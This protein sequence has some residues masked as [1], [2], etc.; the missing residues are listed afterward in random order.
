MIRYFETPRSDYP[1]DEYKER[2]QVGLLNASRRKRIAQGSGTSVTDVNRLV[3]QYQYGQND[4]KMNSKS[5]A[6]AMKAMLGGAGGLGGMEAAC[7]PQQKCKSF[8]NNFQAQAQARTC[9][10]E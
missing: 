5:G 6:A 2:V 4:E 7:H 8:P 3:K 9:L 1:I 10:A